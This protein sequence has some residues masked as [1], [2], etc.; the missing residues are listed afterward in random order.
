VLE[1]V[2][3]PGAVL[4]LD[5]SRDSTTLRPFGSFEYSTSTWYAGPVLGLSGG[6]VPAAA[7]AAASRKSRDPRAAGPRREA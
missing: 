2:G 4:R 7:V 3:E 1:E 6:A 5:A